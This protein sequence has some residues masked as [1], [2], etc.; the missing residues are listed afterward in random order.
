MKKILVVGYAPYGTIEKLVKNYPNVLWFEERKVGM[1]ESAFAM[2]ELV[3]MMDGVLFMAD[4]RLERKGYEIVCTLKGKKMYEM[5][6]F[7]VEEEEE[8]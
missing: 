2:I 4:S 5:D 8:K 7:P 1:G 6:A 3:D